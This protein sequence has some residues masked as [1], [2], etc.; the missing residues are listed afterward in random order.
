MYKKSSL[1]RK[2]VIKKDTNTVSELEKHY[3]IQEDFTKS[4]TFEMVLKHGLDL[5]VDIRGRTSSRRKRGNQGIEFGGRMNACEVLVYTHLNLEFY[6][7]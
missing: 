1:D 2:K 6:S 5:D 7:H 3:S 4:V